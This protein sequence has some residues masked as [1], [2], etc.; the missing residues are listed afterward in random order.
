MAFIITPFYIRRWGIFIIIRNP[1][2][3]PRRTAPLKTVNRKN[4]I[5]MLILPRFYI[6]QIFL[7]QHFIRLPSLEIPQKPVEPSTGEH[8]INKS[9]ADISHNSIIVDSTPITAEEDQIETDYGNKIERHF[10]GG[11]EGEIPELVVVTASD[12]IVTAE[13]ENT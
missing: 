2:L 9:Y 6:I 13:K 1:I 8:I 7:S 11:E 5:S 3:I 4:I 10:V 12:V